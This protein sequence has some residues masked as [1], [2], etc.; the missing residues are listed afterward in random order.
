[1]L[2]K[3]HTLIVLNIA[4]VG[5]RFLAVKTLLYSLYAKVPLKLKVDH[6]LPVKT[7]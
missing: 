1:M 5:R 6:L 4:Y 2:R 3:Q 7:Y